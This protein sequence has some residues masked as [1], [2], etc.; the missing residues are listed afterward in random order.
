MVA[1]HQIDPR[2]IE[3]FP[4]ITDSHPKCVT[5]ILARR[6]PNVVRVLHELFRQGLSQRPLFAKMEPVYAEADEEMPQRQSVMRHLKKHVTPS[7]IVYEFGGIAT[8]PPGAL[9]GDRAS[10]SQA[11]PRTI[12]AMR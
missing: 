3:G 11:A 2:I 12:R 10:M 1:A 6:N 5:C 4:E 8:A 9:K 7:K